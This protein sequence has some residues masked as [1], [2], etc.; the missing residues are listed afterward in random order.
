MAGGSLPAWALGA[1]LVAA[2]LLY[3]LIFMET[4][5][6]ELVDSA[7]Y[8]ILELIVSRRMQYLVILNV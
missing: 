3:I 2:L 5:I 8:S 7:A 1:A 4:L 6:T